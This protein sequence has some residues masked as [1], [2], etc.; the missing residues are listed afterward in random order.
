MGDRTYA[1]DAANLLSDNA[2]A[3]T[4]SGFAQV[5][6]ADAI[7]DLGGLQSS[8]PKQQ[9]RT[10]EALVLDVT[11]IDT[12]TGDESYN[13]IL[14]GSND[15]AF[16]AGNVAILGSFILGGVTGKTTIGALNTFVDVAGRYEFCFSSEQAN[17]K[18]QYLK[19]Y[20]VI[21]GTTPSLSLLAFKAEIPRN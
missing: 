13:L 19:L 10:D 11:A 21:A 1:F 4:A 17:V 5:G 15:S 20:L 3:Y 8:T 7:L 16:G 18:Y 6:G 12:V 14:L 2:A 9:A